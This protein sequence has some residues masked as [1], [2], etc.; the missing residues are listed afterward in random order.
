MADLKV[1]KTI[2][3]KLWENFNFSDFRKNVGLFFALV[4]ALIYVKSSEFL[5]R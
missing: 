2:I 5:S 3:S 1:F 4:V